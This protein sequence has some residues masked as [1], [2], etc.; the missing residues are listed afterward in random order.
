MAIQND[1]DKEKKFFYCCFLQ[2]DNHHFSTLNLP[3]FMYL[4]TFIGIHWTLN[5]IQWTVFIEQAY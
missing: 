5:S 3:M 1:K 2:S 4:C